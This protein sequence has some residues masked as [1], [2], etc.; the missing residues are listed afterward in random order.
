[1]N[2][3]LQDI[4]YALRPL[5]KSP[6]FTLTAVLTLALGIGATTTIF[7]LVFDVLLAPLPYTHPE[8]LTV[9]EERVAE[10][11]VM[12]PTLPMNA[13]NFTF[14][15]QNSRSFQAMAVM[16]EHAVPMGAGGAP[17]K[18]GVLSATPGIFS[19]LEVSPSLGRAFTPDEAQPGRD[20]VAVLMDGLWRRQFQADPAILGKTVTLNGFPYTVIGVMPESFHLPHAQTFASAGVARPQPVEAL[21]P[22][23]FSAEQ[24]QERIGEFNYFGLARLKPGVTLAQA[25]EEIN[26]LQRTITASPSASERGTLSAVLTPYKKV[27]VGDNRKPLLILLAAVAGLL[28]VGCVNITNLLLARAVGRRQQ[29]AVAAA[30][31]ASRMG[32]MRMALCETALLAAVGGA[33]GILLAAVLVPALQHY[34]PAALDFRGQL[35]LD[36]TGGGIAVLLATLATLLAGAAPA[37]MV[38][39]TGPQE[40]LHS[41]AK[42]ASESRGSKQMR[43]VLV[44]VEVAVSMTLV[45]MTGLLTA[46]LFRLMHVERGFQP[47]QIVTATMELPINSYP[48]QQART[49]FYREALR[50]LAQLPGVEYAAFTSVLP[51]DGDRWI[52]MIRIQGDARPFTQLPSEHFRM[53]SSGYFESIRLPLI[54]GRYLTDSDQGKSYALISELT[55]RTL[56]P[57]KNAVGQQFRRAGDDDKEPPFTVIGVVANARTV[58]LAALDPMMVYMPYWYRCDLS[59][60]LLLRTRQ[61]PAAISDSLR[62]TIWSIDPSIPIPAVRALG[63]VVA[64]SVANQRFEMDLLLLFAVS[65]LLLAGLGVYG[66]VNYSVVQR[67]REIGLRL[68]L[69]AQRGTIYRL[70]LRDGLMPVLA[71]AVAGIAVSY[72]FARVVRS[73]LFEVSPYNSGVTLGAFC[74]L[75]AIGAAACLLPARRAASIEP[76]QALRSE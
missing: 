15:Q 29:F 24:L 11:Q 69:G 30:L 76:M 35:H 41:E 26:G 43:R 5:R 38:S 75:V 59:G 51:L 20:R 39:R 31:G 60:G 3:L 55:A 70:T 6:G 1:M 71:G 46:S 47:E 50:R 54:A 22:M 28:M 7:T 33:L 8:Q 49:G 48:S 32:L 58:S 4:R 66:V 42:L 21:L 72:G 62:K 45:I 40:V 2:S 37:W 68:A 73:L 56:W 12:Y 63:G 13:S 65:A 19:V 17:Q 34:L 53:V 10:F 52:D 25:S 27:L 36:W 9:M 18:I 74:V 14:W 23:A 67:Q 16:D 61:N 57:G 64:D 44:A